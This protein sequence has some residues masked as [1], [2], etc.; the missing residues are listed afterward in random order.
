MSEFL[1]K[2]L[3]NVWRNCIGVTLTIQ[4]KAIVPLNLVRS[5]KHSIR[6]SEEL[7]NIR[8]FDQ[9]HMDILPAKV[10]PSSRIHAAKKRQIRPRK[11]WPALP[12]GTTT[13][14][15][16]DRGSLGV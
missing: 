10:T 16:Q 13:L 4:R 8:T 14:R 7:T 9:W 1:T 15:H 3:Q 6:Q 5:M 12:I 11:S 2:K